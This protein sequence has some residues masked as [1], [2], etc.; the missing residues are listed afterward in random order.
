MKEKQSKKNT[1]Q[2][3]AVSSEILRFLLYAVLTSLSVYNGGWVTCLCGVAL[4]MFIMLVSY[5]ELGQT[6]VFRDASICLVF[7]LLAMCYREYF[8]VPIDYRTYMSVV[9]EILVGTLYLRYWLNR[10][11][12]RKVLQ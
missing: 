4:P 3:I 8:A 1:N 5:G 6:A 7:A 12:E 9:P 11:I 10:S 2:L